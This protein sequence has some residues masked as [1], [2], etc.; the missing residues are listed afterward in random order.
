MAD[1]KTDTTDQDLQAVRAVIDAV[2]NLDPGSRMRILRAAET[3]IPPPGPP[4]PPQQQQQPQ[5]PPQQQ[6]P[7]H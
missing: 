2:K 7:Q 4:G 6:G 5:R 3:L 1:Q